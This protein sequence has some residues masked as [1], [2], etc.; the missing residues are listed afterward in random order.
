[1]ITAEGSERREG[2][3]TVMRGSMVGLFDRRGVDSMSLTGQSNGKYTLFSVSSGDPRFLV[4]RDD[5]RGAPRTLSGALPN[6]HGYAPST[7][8][9]VHPDLPC[10]QQESTVLRVCKRCSPDGARRDPQW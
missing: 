4:A 1:M 3:D 10:G 2:R 9:R 8:A 6:G 7:A 5:I